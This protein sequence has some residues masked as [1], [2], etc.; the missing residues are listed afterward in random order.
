MKKEI[1][2]DQLNTLYA[3]KQK[4]LLL[5]NGTIV[6]I[7]DFKIEKET[8]TPKPSIFNKNPKPKE[9]IYLTHMEVRAY[10]LERKFLGTMGEDFCDFLITM[11][12]INYF[13]EKW[14]KLNDQ[15]EGFG[16]AVVKKSDKTLLEKAFEAGREY[17]EYKG[18]VNLE[19]KSW[20]YTFAKWCEK[21][22][23]K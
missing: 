13:R 6:V 7:W 15:L 9:V 16:L 2:P 8:V 22:N 18:N 12:N 17:Q 10:N 1:R 21:N 3:N 4:I 20:D 19:E 11:Y 5:D 23:I 14:I